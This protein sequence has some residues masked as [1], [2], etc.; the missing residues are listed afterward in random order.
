[1]PAL[2]KSRCPSCQAA[3]K[4]SDSLVGKRVRCPGCQQVFEVSS[5]EVSLSPSLAA[6]PLA[7]ETLASAAA[8]TSAEGNQLVE[9]GAAD[10]SPADGRSR[11][12]R[13]ELREI[14]GQGAFGRVYRAFDPHLEREVALKVPTFAADEKHKIQRF[15]AE[16]K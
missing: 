6:V 12:G 10:N 5:V 1:M 11:L 7:N 13:F 3:V 16:A 8:D 2:L 14:L 9:A 15:V 4:V